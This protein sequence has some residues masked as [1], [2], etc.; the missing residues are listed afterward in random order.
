MLDL[1]KLTDAMFTAYFALLRAVFERALASD[2]AT[3][4]SAAERDGE[5][6]RPPSARLSDDNLEPLVAAL[7][8]FMREV[9]YVHGN[10]GSSQ[11]ARL[12]SS[13]AL[14]RGIAKAYGMLGA[15]RCAAVELHRDASAALASGD[16]RARDAGRR[17]LI[18]A[19]SA[20]SMLKSAAE[21]AHRRRRR[22]L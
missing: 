3:T 22:P 8:L 11:N 14:L 5:A 4:A 13:R 2:A 17:R 1:L 16:E 21:H 15:A 10:S 9:G 7:G 19:E 20:S 18:E 6:E 12:K